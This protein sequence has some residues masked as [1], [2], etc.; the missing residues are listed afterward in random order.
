M[1]LLDI[2]AF[3]LGGAAHHVEAGAEFQSLQ[4]IIANLRFNSVSIL[5][6]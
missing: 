6:T 3:T 2:M 5:E 4:T 1:T